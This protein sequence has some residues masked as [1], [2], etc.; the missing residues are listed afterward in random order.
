M[1]VTLHAAADH[2]AL[3]HIERYRERRTAWSCRVA[4]SRA[5]GSRGGPSSSSH[6]SQFSRT[7]LTTPEDRSHPSGAVLEVQQ[8]F[9]NARNPT[10][11]FLLWVLSSADF[12]AGAFVL[13][14]AVRE[15]FQVV[16]ELAQY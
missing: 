13:F 2:L 6:A 14:Q 12:V 15:P 10:K 7:L 8:S 3:E 11:R 16:H 9:A 4:C 5:S 1:A